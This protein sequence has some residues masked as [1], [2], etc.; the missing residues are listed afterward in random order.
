MKGS[1]QKSFE[2]LQ[3]C[4]PSL[5]GKVLLAWKKSMRRPIRTLQDVEAGQTGQLLKE[6]PLDLAV[7]YRIMFLLVNNLDV[8]DRLKDREDEHAFFRAG[9]RYIHCLPDVILNQFLD[10]IAPP[11]SYPLEQ[12]LLC[13]AVEL[14]ATGTAIAI[15]QRRRLD[16]ENVKCIISGQ[17]YTLLE[18]SVR[19]CHVGITSALLEH[20]LDPNRFLTTSP[21]KIWIE[22]QAALDCSDPIQN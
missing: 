5:F 21:I 3:K 6:L 13:S 12:S 10:G 1:L 16:L 2:S 14:G 22:V 18:R 9:I 17:S 19:L 20:G 7:V 15:L 4:N 8:L 11:F